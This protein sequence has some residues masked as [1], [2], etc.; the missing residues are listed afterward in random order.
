M[1]ICVIIKCINNQLAFTVKSLNSV[2]T[3]MSCFPSSAS[4]DGADYTSKS[5]CVNTCCSIESQNKAT[6]SK[7][8]YSS[9]C[10]T[11]ASAL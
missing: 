3:K 11:I 7:I 4:F 9:V 1:K 8:S 5:L 10:K 6:S 2:C